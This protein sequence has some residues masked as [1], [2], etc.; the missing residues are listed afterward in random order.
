M[1]H[2][3]LLFLLM[4]FS[5]ALHAQLYEGKKSGF[6]FFVEVFADSAKVE[7]FRNYYLYRYEFAYKEGEEI[8]VGQS[9]TDTLFR[10]IQNQLY[11]KKKT[12]YLKSS[13]NGKDVFI[14]KLSDCKYDSRDLLR[15]KAYSSRQMHQLNRLQDSLSHPNQTEFTDVTSAFY[16]LNRDSGS[17]EAYA[18]R[19]NRCAD[20]L[21]E[22]IILS[23][24]SAAVDRYY[25]VGLSLDTADSSEVF[26]LLENANYQYEYARYFVFTL[27]QVKPDWLIQYV[28]KNPANKESLL[29]NIKN[30]PHF[31]EIHQKVKESSMNLNGRKEILKQKRKRNTSNVAVGALS[32]TIVLAEVALVVGLIIW[33]F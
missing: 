25:E 11:K 6:K 4:G 14:V 1:R 31:K 29:K 24:R 8:L 15:K 33:I 12:F 13:F 27:S 22:M 3:F 16:Q 2:Y 23:S 7:V 20:S 9:N 17:F 19:T 32:V 18:L 28:D 26:K 5:T 30:H 10:G 21:R